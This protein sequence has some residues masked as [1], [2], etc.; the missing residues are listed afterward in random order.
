MFPWQVWW[1]GSAFCTATVEPHCQLYLVQSC[2]LA[3]VGL[4]DVGRGRDLTPCHAG[5]DLTL[6]SL[7]EAVFSIFVVRK[8]KDWTQSH[9]PA[10]QMSAHLAVSLTLFVYCLTLNHIF[11]HWLCV[12]VCECGVHTYQSEC[13]WRTEDSLGESVLFFHHMGPWV[14]LRPPGSKPL[15]LGHILLSLKPSSSVWVFRYWPSGLYVILC[16][17]ESWSPHRGYFLV[18]R[19]CNRG[20]VSTHSQRGRWRSSHVDAWCVSDTCLR[21]GFLCLVCRVLTVTRSEQSSWCSC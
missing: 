6:P 19:N 21:T 1:L 12:C 17:K 15:S 10:G 13:L 2:S 20:L 18:F 4:E 7:Q 16:R 8:L 14:E 9:M 11:L 5:G 3:L